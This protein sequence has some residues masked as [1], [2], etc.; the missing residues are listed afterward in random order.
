MARV[1]IYVHA[2]DAALRAGADIKVV[3]ATIEAVVKRAVSVHEHSAVGTLGHSRL[4]CVTVERACDRNLVKRGVA[5]VFDR[6]DINLDD[7]PGLTVPA[8]RDHRIEMTVI[9]IEGQIVGPVLEDIVRQVVVLNDGVSVSVQIV[10]IHH[11]EPVQRC[12]E[13]PQIAAVVKVADVVAVE[14]VAHAIG[15][16]AGI[17]HHNVCG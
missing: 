7:L 5:A 6:A 4:H 14:P 1:P 8:G 2:V 11:A 13:R 3:V 12:M 15:C 16:A 17:D 9:C 10:D